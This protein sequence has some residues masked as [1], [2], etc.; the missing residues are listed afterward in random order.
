MFADITRDGLAHELVVLLVQSLHARADP[1]VGDVWAVRIYTLS[2]V[3][4]PATGIQV[5]TQP[6]NIII[7]SDANIQDSRMDSIATL[8]SLRPK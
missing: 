8:P 1:R 5:Y 2:I 4:I 6:A 7:S 3:S